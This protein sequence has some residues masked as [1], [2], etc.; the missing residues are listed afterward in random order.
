[1]DNKN[2]DIEASVWMNTGR[3][4]QTEHDVKGLTFLAI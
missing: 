1:M 4:S 2:T 3:N